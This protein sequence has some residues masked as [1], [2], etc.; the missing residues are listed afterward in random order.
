MVYYKYEYYIRIKE[1]IDQKGF[2]NCL[3]GGVGQNTSRNH[4]KTGGVD[5]KSPRN[6]HRPEFLDS[7]FKKCFFHDC[8][9]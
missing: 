3:D 6:G 4:Q 1:H 5:A 8:I 9:D 7:N 2:L